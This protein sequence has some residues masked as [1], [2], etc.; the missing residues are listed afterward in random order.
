M[1]FR[2]GFG[3][4]LSVI[5]GNA[6]HGYYLTSY[7]DN[8]SSSS[9]Y[10]LVLNSSYH[11][12]ATTAPTG[13]N[14]LTWD[15]PD[16]YLGAKYLTLE[17][18]NHKPSAGACYEI[19]NRKEYSSAFDNKFWYSWSGT[20]KMLSDDYSGREPRAR[21]WLKPYSGLTLRLSAYGSNANAADFYLSAL[22]FNV[23]TP[24]S[25]RVLGMPFLDLT[26]NP[27]TLLEPK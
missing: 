10:R 21:I 22:A 26:T 11:D 12:F 25:C 17:V 16:G 13:R 1:G 4:L 14:Y 15:T 27:P 19:Y 23:T 5:A 18:F 9:Y 6:A 2:A 8:G 24:A 3:L 7:S 20:W